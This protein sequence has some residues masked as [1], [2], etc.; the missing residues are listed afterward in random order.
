MEDQLRELRQQN[1]AE[2]ASLERQLMSEMSV[3]VLELDAVITVC[4]QSANG[5]EPNVSCLLGMPRKLYFVFFKPRLHDEASLMSQLVE[6]TSSCKQPI[7]LTLF[8]FL[9]W[10]AGL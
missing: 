10:M 7:T 6:L 4:V 2:L 3:C 1:S 9:P 5:D 8:G